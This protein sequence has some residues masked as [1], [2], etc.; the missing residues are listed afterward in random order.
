MN[1]FTIEEENRIIDMYKNNTSID[2][3]VEYFDVDEKSIRLVLKKY[4]VDRRY[5]TF[6]EELYKR[7]ELL[8]SNGFTCKKVSEALLISENSVTKILKKRNIHVRTWSE[9]NRIYSLNEHYFDVID[10]PN[11]AYLIGLLYADGCNHINHHSI[12]LSLQEEDRD[13]VEFMKKELEYEGPIRI[14]KLHDKNER[15]KNQCILCINSVCMSERL[16][17]LGVV[18]AKSLVLTF[19]EWLN[20]QLYPY[21]IAGYFDGD[22]CLSYD[23][24]RQKCCTKTAGTMEFCN[25]L[26]EILSGINC[27]HH[28]VHPKQ[29]R[30]SNTYVLQTGGNKSSLLLLDYIYDNN[31]FHM[32]RK[33][34]K[35]LYFK[36]KYLTKNNTQVA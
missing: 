33:H 32:N 7:I 31:G 11:K 14:N 21:F 1:I 30:D 27:K 24:K 35:Y 28:I 17:Q 2:D 13:V 6:T 20:E 36:E 25:K 22:G 4:Q 29:C 23:K 8:Y 5:N 15:Y 18:N 10:T 9:A 16:E 3:I 12:T 19:P 26:S 34:Q